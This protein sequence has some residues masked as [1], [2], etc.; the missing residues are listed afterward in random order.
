[1]FYLF[2]S[3]IFSQW[4]WRNQTTTVIFLRFKTA[5]H[6]FDFT[7][8]E[9]LLNNEQMGKHLRK[10]VFNCNKNFYCNVVL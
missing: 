5:M 4:I 8:R 3:C 9:T 2:R 1:M 7:G 10:E 6:R